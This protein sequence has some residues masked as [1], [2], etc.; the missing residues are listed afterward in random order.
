M[1]MFSE[2]SGQRCPFGFF[3]FT[4]NI[5]SHWS[6]K[7]SWEP[8]SEKQVFSCQL[9]VVQFR[10]SICS[11][12]LM[13]LSWYDTVYMFYDVL[14]SKE[15][16]T[17]MRNE[18]CGWWWPATNQLQKNSMPKTHVFS[19]ILTIPY[20]VSRHMSSPLY[21]YIHIYIIITF[22]HIISPS[23]HHLPSFWPTPC[24]IASG[25][26]PERVLEVHGAVRWLQCSKPCCPDVWKAGE[27]D[28]W[29]D[30]FGTWGDLKLSE[31]K[32]LNY[33]NIDGINITNHGIWLILAKF[34][35]N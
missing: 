20:K 14:I 11:C 12:T 30:V 22:L 34:W 5:D 3:S 25:M 16:T 19:N 9:P 35:L 10:F 26:S 6:G 1:F 31:T 13:I 27:A 29:R 8:G 32:V 23:A 2:H 33:W 21:I 17:Q 24:R 7:F 28:L 18:L 4:S 15:K